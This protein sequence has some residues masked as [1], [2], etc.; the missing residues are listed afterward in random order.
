MSLSKWLRIGICYFSKF[1][2][3]ESSEVRRI[4]AQLDRLQLSATADY[5]L[6]PLIRA[7]TDWHSEDSSE[8]ALATNLERIS[9]L[10]AI[11]KS[12]SSASSRPLLRRGRLQELIRQSGLLELSSGASDIDEVSQ[13]YETELEWLLVGKITV[14]VYGL[15]LS[16]LV[17]QTIPLSNDIW[18]WDEILG[19]RRNTG[20]YFVQTSP[21]RLWNW[22]NDIY[23]DAR[24]RLDHLISRNDNNVA[25]SQAL[26]NRWRQFYGLVKQSL[27]DR[28]LADLHANVL[29]PLTMVRSEMR[30]KQN[31]LKR[32]RE[33]SASGI[34]VLMDEGL[35]LYID[36]EDDHSLSGRNRD[37]SRDLWQ[38][39]LGKSIALMENVLRNVTSLDSGVSEF[40]DTVFVSVEKDSEVVLFQSGEEMPA[41]PAILVERLDHILCEHIPDQQ[42]KSN[43][44][45]RQSGKPSV[46]VRYWLPTT[47]LVFFSG[48][49]LQ[50]AVHRKAEILTWIRDLNAT[51]ID[52]WYN[53][54]VEPAK[55]VIGTIRHDEDSEIAIMSKESLEGDR[56]SLERM[57]VDF[58]IDNP[59]TADGKPLGEAEIGI[60]RAKVKEGDLTPVL[61]AYERDLR[62]PFVGTVRGDLVRALLIQV[63]KTKVD[64]EVALGGIDALL[65]SQ[66]LVFG[67]VGLTPGI[68]VCLG[69]SRWLGGFFG[70]RPS[71]TMGIKQGRV[72]RL[73]R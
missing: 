62:K 8:I 31:N 68:L 42:S 52:F 39:T 65:K 55:K 63:Q 73:L 20:L 16:S 41:K 54:I 24:R 27:R 50:V 47:M 58:A 21:L 37:T 49:I 10:Q 60:V 32:L 6:T 71:W 72:V 11:I 51:V 67:F 30:S 2:N 45:A 34:G 3:F 35:N 9:Q 22:S 64:V 70:S 57:V 1:T 66:E 36:D 69:I 4:D 12:L 19:S 7:A 23:Q 13:K 40:E 61:I 17:D 38:N 14:Q 29:T 44:L 25:T 33:M 48:T 56:A 43:S 18:Y 26:S 15:I 5:P 28:S 59:N 46:L 53:W